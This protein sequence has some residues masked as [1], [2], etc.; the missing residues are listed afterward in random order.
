MLR[1]AGTRD[2]DDE[3][4]VQERPELLTF[5]GFA[6]LLGSI[7]PIIAIFYATQ[8][9]QHDF[10]ADT[11]SDLAR[12]EK[13]WIMD[14]AFYFNAAGMLGLAIASAHAHL[15]RAAWSMGILFLAFLALVVVLLG[16]WD[17]FGAT[18]EGDGMAV[19]TQLTFALGPLYLVGPLFM[20][21][22]VAGEHP[23]MRWMFIIAAIGW[24]VFAVAFKLVP[25]SID[26]ILEKIGIGATYLW[27]IPLSLLFLN[28]GR[29]H[30][31]DGHHKRHQQG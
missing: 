17:E 30:L 26:G 7:I 4:V 21:Q 3:I 2:P 15:G 25:T 22:G 13:K 10:I 20:A 9:T 24:F 18:A 14:V 1:E 31:R 28:R 27:T 19:H 16:L 12:G 11:I 8:V 5:C 23:H 6:G 29:R